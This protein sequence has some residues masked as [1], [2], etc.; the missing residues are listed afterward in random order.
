MSARVPIPI[1]RMA[2]T[3][4][5]REEMR[6][7]N[8]ML[9]VVLRD[10]NAPAAHGG[11]GVGG[12]VGNKNN[13]L[14]PQGGGGRRARPSSLQGVYGPSGT[15]DVRD[16]SSDPFA[17]ARDV[18]NRTANVTYASATTKWPKFV[19]DMETLS[20]TAV[21]VRG[22]WYLRQKEVAEKQLM[23]FERETMLLEETVQRLSWRYLEAKN[24]MEDYYL[25]YRYAQRYGPFD[26]EDFHRHAMPGAAYDRRATDGARQ[27]QRMWWAKWPPRRMWKDICS[28][29][30]GKRVRGYLVRKRWRPIVRMRMH[31]GRYACMI[32]CFR[33]WVEWVGKMKRVR[34]LMSGIMAGS[35][36]NCFNEWRNTVQA[37][38]RE[39]EEIAKKCLKRMLMKAEFSCF[40]SWHGYTQQ[41]RKVKTM[42]RRAI[43]CPSWNKWLDYVAQSKRERRVIRGFTALQSRARGAS[44]RRD[45]LALTKLCKIMRRLVRHRKSSDLV[46]VALN[47]LV[48]QQLRVMMDVELKN[49]VEEE[50]RRLAEFSAQFSKIE[51]GIRKLKLLA[52]KK[53]KGKEELKKLADEIYDKKQHAKRSV[54]PPRE[55][56]NV[57]AGGGGGGVV[58]HPESSMSR[59]DCEELARARILNAAC[60]EAKMKMQHDFESKR[61]PRLQSVDYHKP[62]VFIYEEHYLNACPNFAD[63]DLCLKNKFGLEKF[64]LFVDRT[65]GVSAVKFAL[66][67][68]MHVAK[69]KLVSSET[70]EYKSE[71]IS[72]FNDHID[73]SAGQPLDVDVGLKERVGLNLMR[74][75]MEAQKNA[76][77]LL[78][79]KKGFISGLLANFQTVEDTPLKANIFDEVV[80]ECILFLRAQCWQQFLSSNLGGEYTEHL[81]KTKKK[82]RE[83]RVAEFLLERRTGYKKEAAGVM[84]QLKNMHEIVETHKK[85]IAQSEQIAFEVELENLISEAAEVVAE[86]IEMK[87]VAQEKAKETAI[88][89]MATLFMKSLE[90]QIIE[91]LV[92]GVVDNLVSIQ[93]QGIVM[94]MANDAVKQGWDAFIDT[95]VDE[96]CVGAV[97]SWITNKEHLSPLEKKQEA[98]SLLIQRRVRGFVTRCKMRRMVATRFIRQYDVGSSNYFWCDTVTGTTNWEKPLIFKVMWK[99]V[100]ANVTKSMLPPPGP[101]QATN[102]LWRS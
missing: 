61:P 17:F 65:Q 4:V 12:S 74:I 8:A 23:H 87:M 7:A 63:L 16:G 29:R 20:R 100:D 15:S 3:D 82:D 102:F 101:P 21:T 34:A 69:W 85:C 46:H 93:I 28:T 51:A 41:C 30:M 42:M 67:F 6:E 89:N 57:A 9:K 32:R 49:A 96:L 10:K 94:K 83:R 22:A 40:V 48:E 45:F 38:K 19:V 33:P 60:E 50:E 14:A 56:A 76:E 79:K 62:Q 70:P 71:A 35:K 77:I 26:E 80:F 52:M 78:A 75:E 54:F 66:N 81:L 58:H 84:V 39:R 2:V 64:D 73:A 13:A 37:T 86:E 44:S 99:R 5:C 55:G 1:S 31:H 91:E 90:N 24:R 53:G 43:G 88:N 36:R 18:A 97:K 72:I 25:Y 68:L 95:Y 11:G 98:G 59:E 27:F 47:A 92:G